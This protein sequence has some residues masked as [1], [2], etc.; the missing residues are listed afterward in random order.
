MNPMSIHPIDR[1]NILRTIAALAVTSAAFMTPASV[2]AADR[3][4]L[5][6]DHHSQIDSSLSATE[7]IPPQPVTYEDGRLSNGIVFVA[8]DEDGTFSIHDAETTEALLSNSR[9]GLPRGKPG[10]VVSMSAEDVEDA[11]GV[12]KR[13]VLEVA[14]FNELGYWGRP[15]RIYANRI[16]TYT[17]Y[18]NNPALVCGFGLKLP[19]YIS[20]R[21]DESTP[22]AGGRFFGGK[23]ISRP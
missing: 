4:T 1:R 16:Y 18:E 5:D 13:V 19:N 7:P 2:N 11:L 12:G 10:K 3:P 21:L 6:A 22:L 20:L 14:D 15:G 23:E 8:F 17:L 9:F